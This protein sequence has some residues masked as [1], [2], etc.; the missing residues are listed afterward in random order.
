MSIVTSVL[1]SEALTMKQP[2]W[3]SKVV[4][5]GTLWEQHMLP[6]GSCSLREAATQKAGAGFEGHTSNREGG[7]GQG[8]LPVGPLL[9]PLV[10]H[11]LHSRVAVSHA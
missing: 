2:C 6:T 3:L 7:G 5:Y 11:H 10:L 4:G 1:T 9:H 8:A